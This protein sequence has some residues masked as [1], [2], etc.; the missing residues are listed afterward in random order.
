MPADSSGATGDV[1]EQLQRTLDASRLANDMLKAGGK[2]RSKCVL[3]PWD[4]YA[5]FQTPVVTTTQC[6][7]AAPT[8]VARSNPYRVVLMFSCAF[9]AAGTLFISPSQAMVG[10]ANLA[11]PV[12]VSFPPFILTQKDHGIL[13]QIEWWGVSVTANMRITVVEGILKGWPQSKG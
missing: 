5:W 11:I 2:P 8:L 6:R 13:A 9:G 12:P 10:N 7:T 4:E 1:I 3:S